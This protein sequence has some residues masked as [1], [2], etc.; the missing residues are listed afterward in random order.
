MILVID[1]MRNTRLH[2]LHYAGGYI[3]ANQ[4]NKETNRCL[5]N[6]I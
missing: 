2:Y 3:Y 1:F 6:L 4:R 5:I